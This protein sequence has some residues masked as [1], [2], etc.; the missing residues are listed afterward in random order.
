MTP[1]KRSFWVWLHRWA[2]LIMA[3]FLII[4]GITG[5]LLAFYPEL[6]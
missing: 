4:V 3:S 5:S 1:L 6:E 2:G